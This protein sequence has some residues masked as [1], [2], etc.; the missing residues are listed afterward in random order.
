MGKFELVNPVILGTFGT[1]YTAKSSEEAAKL[2]WQKLTAD[3]Q[4]VSGNIPK[5]MFTLMD[6]DNELYHFVV[7]EKTNGSNVDFNIEPL[8]NEMSEAEKKSFIDEVK[9][10]R[11]T[12]TNVMN[13]QAGG[14]SYRKYDR[15]DD[16]S[17]SDSDDE[18]EM[19]K[20]L[21]LNNAYKPIS[22]WWYTPVLYRTTSV[23][24]P[25]FVAPLSPY[26]HLWVPKYL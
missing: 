26:V 24:S 18:D 14:K 2:F 19:F 6:D 22:Y 23:Y 21:R 9:K 1:S 15:D 12:T 5:F 13:K 25:S 20:Y 17:S 8:K 16:S 3:G 4:F 10:I 11:T 7:K